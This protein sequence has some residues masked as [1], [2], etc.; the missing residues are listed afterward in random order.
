MA[1]QAPLLLGRYLTFFGA[2]VSKVSFQVPAFSFVIRIPIYKISLRSNLIADNTFAKKSDAF[3][4][5]LTNNAPKQYC[6]AALYVVPMSWDGL[7]TI[8]MN[9]DNVALKRNGFAIF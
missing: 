6:F 7:L 1:F 8:S 9:L 2:S 5:I 4:L 3:E